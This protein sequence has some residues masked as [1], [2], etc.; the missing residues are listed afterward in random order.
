[1][2]S[3]KNQQML[4][5]S[6][7]SSCQVVAEHSVPEKPTDRITVATRSH[8]PRFSSCG[9]ETPFYDQKGALTIGYSVRWKM[10]SQKKPTH[11]ITVAT[12]FT[13]PQTK[14]LEAGT[15]EEMRISKEALF[16]GVSHGLVKSRSKIRMTSF[17][18]ASKIFVWGA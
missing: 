9:P 6:F 11:H 3:Q 18:P 17:V 2:A 13:P 16:K 1:M 8:N 7:V 12:I 14:I 5:L 10:A 15:K 4:L